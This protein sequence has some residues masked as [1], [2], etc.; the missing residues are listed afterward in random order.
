MDVIN[1]KLSFAVCI[2]LLYNLGFNHIT[3]YEDWKLLSI[4]KKDLINLCNCELHK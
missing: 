1:S 2:I 3:F 4:L